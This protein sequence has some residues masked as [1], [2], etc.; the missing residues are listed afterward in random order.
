MKDHLN[1]NSYRI[2]E[3]EAEISRKTICSLTTRVTSELINSNE[4]TKIMQPQN[5]SGILLIDGKFVPV[6]NTKKAVFGFLPKSAKRRGKTKGGLVIISYIDYLTHDVPVYEISLSENMYDIEEGFRKLK[7]IGY[8]LRVV[9]CDE[10]MGE[11]A[12]VAKKIFPNIFIQTCLTHYSRAI[13]RT[14]KAK[15]AKRSIRALEN[16]LN[17]MDGNFLIA[18]HH[19]ARAQAV[20][21]VNKIAKLEFEYGYLIKI[22]EIFQDIFWKAKDIEELNYYENE[23]NIMISHMDLKRYP[24]AKRIK[25]RYLDYYEK[26]EQIITSIMHPELEIPHTTNLIEGY[27][28]TTLEIRF[29]SI[30]GFKSEHNARNYI[31]ALILKYRFHKFTDCKSKF[32][33]LNGRSSLEIAEPKNHQNFCTDD[34]VRFCRNL[35]MRP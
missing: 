21:I 2:L 8:P 9:V 12:Q 1:R 18:T 30:R 15:A 11:I 32:K 5:Y 19:Y 33:H 4:L 3:N 35:K 13:D 31:N 7:E 26:R 16:R 10:S 34:W 17:K 28:S 23:L 24:Y 25:D 6:R 22:E 20:S 14:F 27:H 29:T